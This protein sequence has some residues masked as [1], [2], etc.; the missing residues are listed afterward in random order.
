MTIVNLKSNI[1]DRIEMCKDKTQLNNVDNFLNDRLNKKRKDIDNNYYRNNNKNIKIENYNNTWNYNKILK[2]EN[3]FINLNNIYNIEYSSN[4]DNQIIPQSININYDKNLNILSKKNSK[5]HNS[6]CSN[7]DQVN[8]IVNCENINNIY[9]DNEIKETTQTM[10]K[11]NNTEI[12]FTNDINI[13]SN[14]VKKNNMTNWYSMNKTF[15]ELEQ[16]N[17][18]IVELNN[19]NP[20]LVN[21][22]NYTCEDSKYYINR[23]KNILEKDLNKAENLNNTLNNNEKENEQNECDKLNNLV[24][25]PNSEKFIESYIYSL[26]KDYKTTCFYFPYLHYYDKKIY[27]EKEDN[28]LKI[29]H[30]FLEYFRTNIKIK[31][32]INNFKKIILRINFLSY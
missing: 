17:N 27:E 2:S 28:I 18:K 30:H 22:I 31:K 23:D 21:N 19:V 5:D 4:G 3:N 15:C 6:D 1:N 11:Q 7:F 12:E 10:F 20:Q 8:N 26:L 32:K 25:F 16:G 24:K 29:C 9:S 13:C 14:Y